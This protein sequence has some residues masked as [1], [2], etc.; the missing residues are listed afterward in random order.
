MSEDNTRVYTFTKKDDF[1]HPV[2]F[3]VDN[4]TAYPD[5]TR[6]H[7]I[8]D[9][10]DAIFDKEY[11]LFTNQTATAMSIIAI[12]VV[13]LILVVAN[14]IGGG[15]LYKKSAELDRIAQETSLSCIKSNNQAIEQMGKFM[16]VDIIGRALNASN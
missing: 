5:Y 10:E 7:R 6:K 11:G 13:L 12:I 15:F 4:N 8:K 2:W 9:T 1:F 14:L 3:G 16:S